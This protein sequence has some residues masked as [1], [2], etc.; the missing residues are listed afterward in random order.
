[1]KTF[2]PFFAFLSLLLFADTIVAARKDGGE[3]W[4]AV[5][6]DQPMPHA[7]QGLVQ[8][9]VASAGSGE[10]NEEMIITEDF[11]RPVRPKGNEKTTF[12]EDLEPRPNASAYGDDENLKVKKSSSFAEDF[13]PRPTHSAYGGVSNLKRKRSSSFTEDF[14]PRPN[15]S[16][17][18]DDDN[19]KGERKSFTDDFEQVPDA[20]IYHG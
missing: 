18:G 9:E 10:L 2:L 3:Y 20:T 12:C 19:L 5:M 13:E 8:I 7:L 14:E 6:K 11:K 17:Y 4:R 15:A 16:A 1:M